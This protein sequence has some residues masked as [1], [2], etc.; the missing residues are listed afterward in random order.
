LQPDEANNDFS[1]GI[2]V[3]PSRKEEIT[4][5]EKFALGKSTGLERLTVDQHTP[6]RSRKRTRQDDDLESTYLQR[7]ARE[8]AKEDAQRD[9]E[10]EHKRQKREA[11][12]KEL[13][14]MRE[15][16]TVP[17]VEPDHV[18]E[19]FSI[20]QHETLADPRDDTELEKASR[21][22]FLANVSTTAII[23]KSS[24]KILLTHLASHIPALT[25]SDPPHKVES[26]RFRSTAFSSNVPKKAA[27]AKKE[28]M[29]TT[30]KSTNAYA[31]YST[32]L[33]AREA[34]RRL[35]GS[36]VLDRHL[37]V[38]EVAHPA[39]IDH[40]RCVF[41]GNLGFVDDASQMNVTK[42]AEENRKPK[43]TQPSDVEEGLW[44]QFS[45]AGTVESV[46][47]VR[48]AKT[49]VGKG[50]AYVQFTDQNGVE[51]ALLYNEK[52][53]PPLLPRKLRVVRAKNP[54]HSASA[55]QNPAFASRRG[56]PPV[57][58]GDKRPPV[59]GGNAVE[60]SLHGRVGKLLGRAGAANMR[61]SGAEKPYVKVASGTVSKKKSIRAPES[62]VFEGHRAS[63]TQGNSGL[64]LGGSGKRK[65]GR[66][67]DRSAKRGAAWKANSA[68]K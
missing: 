17:D 13:S 54:K 42:D 19:D 5:T 66:P 8:E 11:D 57:R 22:V 29:D 30:T 10:K 3:L 49:R 14:P 21:T 37:R 58:N 16:G 68:A 33:A 61:M 67:R 28:L 32:K 1:D 24:R 12:R 15:M 34:A 41:V 50:F 26:L 44:Q 48:D 23:S 47:V 52:R 7:L 20:P 40:R 59:S 4:G 62:F 36:V 18:E 46:R 53:F 56:L 43:K 38:D 9:A 63:S 64:K 55:S 27:F 25:A 6:Q 51:A 31:V 2:E 45:N 65:G 35:N 60:Q 39:K